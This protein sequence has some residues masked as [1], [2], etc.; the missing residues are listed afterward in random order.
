MTRARLRLELPATVWITELSTEHPDSV[1]RLLTGIEA[2][3][4]AIEVGELEGPEPERAA[5]RLRE[6]PAVHA[7][8]QLHLD[9][10]A[11][12]ARY[13]VEDTSLYR[14]LREAEL[15]P[16]HPIEVQDGA[17]ESQVTASREHLAR[18]REG[19]EQ[20]GVEH[21]VLALAE[22]RDPRGLLTES[23]RQALLVALRKGYL[24]VP[25]EAKLDEVADELAM[26]PSTASGVIRRGQARVLTWFLAGRPD[27]GR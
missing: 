18:V 9:Q 2:E 8:E 1:F 13:R 6:H 3:G 17:M 4:E 20:A 19:L 27:G 21:D 16:Q 22:R 14:F 7:Y 23:Q 10:D 24:E 12:L 26:D 11:S 5:R 25:R 15:P